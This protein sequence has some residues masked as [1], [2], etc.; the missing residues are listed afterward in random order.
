[1]RRF[2]YLYN[3][4]IYSAPH[5]RSYLAEE[6]FAPYLSNVWAGMSRSEMSLEFTPSVGRDSPSKDL[7]DFKL[8]STW[9]DTQNPLFYQSHRHVACSV[10]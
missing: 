5:M 7:T 6:S 10:L 3:T 9:L 1:M 4:W 2:T 8:I